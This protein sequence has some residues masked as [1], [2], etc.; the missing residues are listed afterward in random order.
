L[1]YY[2]RYI[3]LVNAITPQEILEAAQRYLHPDRLAV[4]V[5]GP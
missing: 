1:D 5:A 3:D 4:A 2:R